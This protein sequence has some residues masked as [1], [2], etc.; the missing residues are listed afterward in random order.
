M[1]RFILIIIAVVIIFALLTYLLHRLTIKRRF[2]K[3]LFPILILIPTIYNYY[4]SRL[5]SEGFEALGS[6]LV[7]FILF[8]GFL[9]SLV[10]GL[11]FDFILPK[12]KKK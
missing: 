12:F 8:T 10:S 1:E 3:Y 5:P 6:F 9:S 7:A 4:Q 11:F 2:I